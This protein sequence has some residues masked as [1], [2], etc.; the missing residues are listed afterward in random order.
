MNEDYLDPNPIESTRSEKVWRVVRRVAAVLALLMLVAI[1]FIYWPERED[2]AYLAAA[3]E[4]YNVRILRDEWGVPHIFGETDVD[5]AYG[6]AYAHAEDDFLTTQQT[7]LAAR[8]ELATVYGR[9]AAP[10]DYMVR[11]LRIADVIEAEYP[12]LS[13]ETRA[14]AEAYADGLN[15]YAALHEADALVGLFPVTG[16]DIIAGS[17]HK[18]P[19]FFGLDSTLS[20][21]FAETRQSEVSPRFAEPVA[22]ENSAGSDHDLCRQNQF[23]GSSCFPG[24]NVLAVNGNRSANGE[25]FLAVNAHQPWTGPVAWYEA[26]VHSEEGWDMVGALFPGMPVLA[27]GYNRHLGWGFT[28]NYADRTDV[29]VLEMNPDNPNQYRFDGEWRELERR[30]APITVRLLGRLRITVKEEVLWSVYGPVVQQDHG[31][32]AVRYVGMGRAGLFEQLYRMNKATNFAEWLAAMEMLEIPTFNTGYA[33]KEG[34]IFYVYN[35]LM[36]IR[37]PHYD[38][39]LYLPGNTSETLW[40]ETLPFADLPQVMNPASGFLVN[41]NHT[42]FAATIGPE[43][44]DPADYS[45]TFGIETDLNNRAMR[46]LTLFGEDPAITEAEFKAYKYD[47]VY[48]P[49]SQ[50]GD[51]LR[52]LFALSLPAGDRYHDAREMLK[53]WDLATNPENTGAALAILTTYTLD[54]EEVENLTDEQIEMA[55][56]ETVDRMLEEFGRVD[57]PWSEVNRLRRGEVDLGL[58]GGPDILHAIVG[59]L[60]EDMRFVGR[61]GDAYVA[62]VTWDAAGNVTARNIHQFGSATLDEASPHYADQAPLFARRELR[63]VWMDEAVIRAHLEREYRPGE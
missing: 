24:S 32:Y 51:F 56:V 11:L 55:F 36:P 23:A 7:L 34:N 47:M 12:N 35:G 42:P 30:P 62:L 40:T 63:P 28:V 21:L 17:I 39:Q 60:A 13:T 41:T 2:L 16:G 14:I 50:L 31:T 57:V 44:P 10:N 38:W 37:D 20:E 18:S 5:A 22:G 25:T 58:G 29:Y 48:D 6:L 3:G 46:A 8:G 61:Q 1:V 45:P 4:K 27:H 43:N 54:F 15:H 26:H 53:T 49:D 19:L 52:R 33:D 9:D 59:N